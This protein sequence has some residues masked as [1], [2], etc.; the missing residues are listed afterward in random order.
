M[1]DTDTIGWYNVNAQAYA[2]SA[3]G[4]ADMDQV[5]A[6]IA[7]LQE[8]ARVLDVGCGSGRDTDILR[9]KGFKVT[10]VD[11]SGKLLEI[12]RSNHPEIKFVQA[13]M[14][15]LPFTNGSFDGLWVHASLLHL[16]TDVD[17]Q[18]AFLEFQ[19]VLTDEGIVHLTLKARETNEP[20]IRIT[21]GDSGYGRI[22]RFFTLEEV[23]IL[24]SSGGFAIEKL[25]RYAEADKHE[26]GRPGLYWIH[27]LAR[28][29]AV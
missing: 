4:Y 19:R 27:A 12:A 29:I 2:H 1:T 14:T 26:G 5:E 3:T 9:K 24:V 6:F 15:D 7:L 11:L 23:G 21:D 20:S 16:E 18:R 13:S 25:E 17:L 22:F 28:K 10:G 8:D